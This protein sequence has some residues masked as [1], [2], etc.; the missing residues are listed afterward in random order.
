MTPSTPISPLATSPLATPPLATPLTPPTVPRSPWQLF[1]GAVHRWRSSW[2]Q[3]RAERLPR[4]VISIGNLCWGGGGKTPLTAALGAWLR[5]WGKDQTGT[6]DWRVA[7]LS[8]GY[9]RKDTET[10]IVSTGDGPMLP[11]SLAGDEPVLL[12]GEL[13]GVAV[14]VAP[15]RADAGRAAMERLEPAPNL[16]LLDDGFSHLHLARDLDLL[17]FPASDPFAGGRLAPT[18][19]LREP[20]ASVRRAGAVL[21]TGCD[22]DDPAAASRGRELA[23]ALRPH[24][25]AGPGFTCYLETAPARWVRGGDSEAPG[26]GT[27]VLLVSAIARPANFDA[28]ARRIGFEIADQLH[29]GDHHPYPDASL[30]KIRETFAQ[31][32]AEAVLVTTK[33]RVKLLGRLDDL[34]L[35][36]LPVRARPEDA[37]WDWLSERLDDWRRRG[38]VE[39]PA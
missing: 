18:G 3:S 7:I 8:R 16:F 10:R 12:A 33:D 14:V 6:Q 21:L 2:Y 29:F 5:D 25:F 37:F 9:G 19:R 35:A 30:E 26:P 36:E 24:G 28:S 13:P 38:I 11:P 17:A 34:P 39:I 1:Y 23:E 4:P 22:P 31:C 15:R 20:L 32:G 27:P